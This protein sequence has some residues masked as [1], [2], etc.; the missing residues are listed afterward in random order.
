MSWTTHQGALPKGFR[1]RVPSG[2]SSRSMALRVLTFVS[3]VLLM[4]CGVTGRELNESTTRNQNVNA[5]IIVHM[6]NKDGEKLA[7]Y[8]QSVGATLEPYGGTVTMSGRV[9]EVPHGSHPHTGVVILGFPEPGA[10]AAW[11]HSDAYQSLIPLRDEAMES[12]FIHYAS[13]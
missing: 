2:P 5:F 9:E 4:G 1:P 10:A 6:T 7:R 13:P 3:V 12:V 11:Y 8:R